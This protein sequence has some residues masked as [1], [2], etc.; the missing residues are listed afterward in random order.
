MYMDINSRLR[1]AMI[2]RGINQTELAKRVGVSPQA[3]QKWL[4][5]GSDGT[6]PRLAKIK[7][8]SEV[9]DV[10]EQWILT[11]AGEPDATA[12]RAERHIAEINELMKSMSE[13]D[14]SIM[15]ETAKS[16]TY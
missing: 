7:K 15:L 6:T 9:L 13:D 10:P 3:V 8:I 12:A 14:L 5:K 2:L 16:T 11:G 1:N 4:A